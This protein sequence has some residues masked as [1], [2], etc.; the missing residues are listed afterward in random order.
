[1]LLIGTTESWFQSYFIEG[2]LGNWEEFHKEICHRFNTEP[3]KDVVESFNGLRQIGS[4]D[5]FLKKN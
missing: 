3:P 2:G 4:V 5:E 1:M